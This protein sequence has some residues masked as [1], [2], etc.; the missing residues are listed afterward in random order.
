MHKD[1]QKLSGT[2]ESILV[3][4]LHQ[5]ADCGFLQTRQNITQ[6]ANLICRNRLGTDC[7]EV[8][9]TWVGRFLD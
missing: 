2:E 1:Q 7:E 8:G 9:D 4:F 5:S 3:D 6:Y